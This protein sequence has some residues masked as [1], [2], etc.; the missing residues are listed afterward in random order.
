V[1]AIDLLGGKSEESKFV[2]HE[3]YPF[4]VEFLSWLD[5]TAPQASKQASNKSKKQPLKAVFCFLQ[6]YF[7]LCY[8]AMVK[9]FGLF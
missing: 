6:G 2:F 5:I 4:W 8:Q 9:F 3:E 7:V 1:L